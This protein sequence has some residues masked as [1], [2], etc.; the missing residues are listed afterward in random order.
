MGRM[1]IAGPGW[2]ERLL[3]APAD[4]GAGGDGGGS[5]GD[6]GGAGGQGGGA[7]A[8][9]GGE[10][11]GGAGGPGGEGGATGGGTGGQGGGG[12]DGGA[13]AVKPWH[14]RDGLL[15]A[16]ERSW[17]TSK[18]YNQPMDEALLIRALRGHRAAEGRLGKPADA[19]MDRP[20]KDQPVADWMKANAAVFG[21]PE[22]PEGY[23]IQRP[24]LPEGMTWDEGLEGKFRSIAH[25][26]GMT[27]AQVQANVDMF[28]E[29]RA[30]EF[31]NVATEMRTASDAMRQELER[32]WGAQ[33]GAKVQ[34]AQKGAQAMAEKAGLG[35][36]QILAIGQLLRPKVG[37]AGIMRLFAAVGEAMGDDAFVPS[38]AGSGGVGIAMTPQEAKAEHDRF[39]GPDGDYGKAWAKGDQASVRRLND[40]RLQLLRIASGK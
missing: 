28:A 40:K 37:D 18:G 39:V 14:E 27:P 22:A 36:E 1:T 32:D 6:A 9:Q 8:G 20:A 5:G 34:L 21:L 13:G 26:N 29:M 33:Y 35:T 24:Q 12:G 16:E 23:E 17:I 25:A 4:G 38:A 19:L 10:G 15:S 31:Q 11:G 3:R 30:A 7:G 2:L